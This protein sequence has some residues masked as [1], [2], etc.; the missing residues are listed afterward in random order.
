[1]I[2][3][4]DEA[5]DLDSNLGVSRSMRVEILANGKQ[6]RRWSADDRTMIVAEASAAGAKVSV[7]ARKHGLSPGQ[8]FAWRREARA[9]D[10]GAPAAPGLVPVHV[11]AP[12]PTATSQQPT[13]EEPPRSARPV[14]TKKGL[15]EIDFGSGRRVRVDADVDA[16]ALA[17]VLDVLERR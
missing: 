4:I 9:K 14:A 10:L 13:P 7:V 8:I 6:R 1:L 11:A 3:E 2:C 17:V 5:Y 12:E 15:I 16:A